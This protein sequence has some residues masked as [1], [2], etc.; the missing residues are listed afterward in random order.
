[1]GAQG[2]DTTLQMFKVKEFWAVDISPTSCGNTTDYKTRV[3]V[4]IC[5]QG[6]TSTYDQALKS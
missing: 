2:P 4:E 5:V 1:M 3:R 6:C